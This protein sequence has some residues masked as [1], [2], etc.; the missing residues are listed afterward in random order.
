MPEGYGSIIGQCLRGTCNIPRVLAISN[1]LIYRYEF[2]NK[3]FSSIRT[4]DFTI[5]AELDIGELKNILF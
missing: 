2:A 1:T 3:R 5:A 4:H